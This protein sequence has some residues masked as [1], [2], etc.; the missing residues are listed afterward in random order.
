M[1]YRS[2]SSRPGEG[3]VLVRCTICVIIPCFLHLYD[4]VNL[5]PALKWIF[6]MLTRQSIHDLYDAQQ[7]LRT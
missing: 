1:A 7:N 4:Y 3:A 6:E 5:D 2:I